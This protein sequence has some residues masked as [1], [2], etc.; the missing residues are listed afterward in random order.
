MSGSSAAGPPRRYPR[1]PLKL[2]LYVAL[3]GDMLRKFVPLETQ[4]VS[5]GGLSFETG[6]ALPMDAE[7][8]LL[9]SRLGDLPGEAYIEGRVAHCR[10][11]PTNGRYRVGVEF[12]GFVNVSREALLGR[13]AD[14]ESGARA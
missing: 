7:S 12:I 9:V 11:D 5:G 8:R 10:Q 4:D 1:V 14:W 6:H 2:P 3:D 13:I